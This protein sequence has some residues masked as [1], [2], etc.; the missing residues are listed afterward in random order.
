MDQDEAS[1]LIAEVDGSD[2]A[3][4]TDRLV[5]LAALLPDDDMVGFSGQAAQWLF[6]DVKAT[7][8]YG[9]FTSTV[10]TAHAFCS[11]QIAGLVRLLPDNPA[12]PMEAETLEALAAIAVEAGLVDVEV[13]G[14]LLTLHDRFRSYSAAHLHEHEMRLER[15]MAEV[16]VVGDEDPLLLDA[17]QAMST[18][19]RLVY[20]P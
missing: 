13:Q 6:E 1:R 10:L 17:R 18:A 11:L 3:G 7:W 8:L 4:R 2:H 20:R 9:C 5:E 15:H 16:E 19:V 12:L 14:A